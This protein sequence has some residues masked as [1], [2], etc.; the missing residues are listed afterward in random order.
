MK[1]N[2]M[3]NILVKKS[4]VSFLVFSTSLLSLSSCSLI[5][6]QSENLKTEQVADANSAPVA[7]SEPIVEKEIVKALKR[8]VKDVDLKAKSNES[9]MKKRLVVLPFLDKN[10]A[11]QEVTRIKAKNSLIDELNKSD[12]VI[13]LEANQLKKDITQY[14]KPDTY[15][16]DLS[17]LA[18]DSQNDGI[19]SL[20]EGKILEV[21]LNQENEAKS[22]ATKTDNKKNQKVTFEAVVQVRIVNVRSGKET[23]HVVK[24][25]SIVDENSNL[26]DRVNSDAFFAKN[27]EITTALL[28]DAFS[29]YSS[30][31]VDL[32]GQTTW[33]GRIAAF[34]GD[35]I[36]LNVGRISGV[37]IG[38]ILKVVEDGSEVYDPEIG[39]HIG[40]VNG[41]AKGTVEVVDFFGQDGAIGII[42]SGAGFKEND[43]VE[44]Y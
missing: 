15:E 2:Q 5:P 6:T 27:P 32:M 39:Y 9:G 7:K 16:Y 28:K 22:V 31:I 18:K 26:I 21:R 4:L 23:F 40:K 29:D 25:V 12:A 10:E 44:L 13:A 34:K 3:Q 30:Q 41:Q 38:D 24:T 19:S 8:Q 20:L 14:L 1:Q 36:F 37:Q 42:H 33:E 35:K 11:H 43:R 17:K